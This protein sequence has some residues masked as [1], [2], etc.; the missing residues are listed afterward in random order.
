MNTWGYDVKH[1]PLFWT[2]I[3]K[4]LIDI[5]TWKDQHMTISRRTLLATAAA[6]S[7]LPLVRARSQGAP[8]IKIGVLNDMSGP[9]MNTGGPTSI[10]CT[11]QALEDFGVSGKG[12]NVEVVNADHQN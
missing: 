8:T 12:L 5:Q 6:A 10:I 7:A 9:Y 1:D 2:G 4:L 3:R 11:K